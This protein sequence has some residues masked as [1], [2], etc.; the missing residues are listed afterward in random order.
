VGCEW[1]HEGTYL[2]VAAV[3][4]SRIGQAFT[5]VEEVSGKEA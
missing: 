4:F 3:L 1:H 2:I 5:D